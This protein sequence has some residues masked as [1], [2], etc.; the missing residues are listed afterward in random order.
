MHDK[1]EVNGKGTRGHSP[2][3][4]S[5]CILGGSAA[6]NADT[7]ALGDSVTEGARRVR[8]QFNVSG[9]KTIDIIKTGGARLIDLIYYNVLPD[10]SWN[11]ATKN[12][13]ARNKAK[14]LTMIEDGVS[15][16]V[17]A[18]TTLNS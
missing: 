12:E 8:I 15:A 1:D 9:S 3:A 10:P 11:D 16:A 17:K 6:A 4:N 2:M 18:A 7:A 14:A 5:G 13:F